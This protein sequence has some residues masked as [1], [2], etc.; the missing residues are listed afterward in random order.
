MNRLTKTSI[1]L[2]AVALVLALPFTVGCSEDSAG[3]VVSDGVTATFTADS[4][5]VDNSI[6][7]Q[8]GG[9]GTTS[10][11]FKVN[12]VV[13]AIDDIKGVNVNVKF[14]NGLT[15]F[16]S[17]DF[18]GN[19]LQ[20]AL[21]D[22]EFDHGAV[23]TGTEDTINLWGARRGATTPGIPMAAGKTGVL[24]TLTFKALHATS[25]VALTIDPDDYLVTCATTDLTCPSGAPT[26]GNG[27]M[28]AN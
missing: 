24:C 1:A 11:T 15:E 14:E 16:V 5:P 13:G 23:L 7:L 25:G 10:E 2:A 4:S 22:A 12:V 3:N 6:S 9:A 18:T 17:A 21:P 8:A 20:D 19:F 26:F 27:M 28:T